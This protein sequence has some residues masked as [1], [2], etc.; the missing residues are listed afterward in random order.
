MDR[1]PP[2]TAALSSTGNQ[3]GTDFTPSNLCQATVNIRSVTGNN[4]HY[5][6]T[7]TLY[8]DIDTP[9]LPAFLVL[10]ALHVVPNLKAFDL[11]VN[12][13]LGHG[14]SHLREGP[15][16]HLRYQSAF[17]SSAPN[18]EAYKDHAQYRNQ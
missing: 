11:I 12:I 5:H 10:V 17:I 15:S 14:P 9:G 7:T 2:A 4:R 18:S 6:L 16:Y 1:P 3:P 8:L 13:V